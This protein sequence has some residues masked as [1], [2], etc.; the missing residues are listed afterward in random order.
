[1]HNISE[2]FLNYLQI[3]GHLLH[4]ISIITGIIILRQVDNKR[5]NFII[6]YM[7]HDTKFFL[8]F[9]PN[10]QWIYFLYGLSPQL[11]MAYLYRHSSDA[12][13]T[14]MGFNMQGYRDNCR[15]LSAAFST[16]ELMTYCFSSNN[17]DFAGNG[18]GIWILCFDIKLIMVRGGGRNK[19]FQYKI[20][21]F[22]EKYGRE[23]YFQH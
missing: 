23:T 5:F 2:K 3:Q 9:N 4:F 17:T 20:L 15:T 8:F 16:I 12:R 18:F 6:K 19:D 22:W 14:S 1:M 7:V 13:A 11:L 10:F 21:R